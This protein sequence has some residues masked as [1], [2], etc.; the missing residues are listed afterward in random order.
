MRKLAWLIIC[1]VLLTACGTSGDN[2][3]EVDTPEITPAPQIEPTPQIEPAPD[4]SP[5]ELL[6]GYYVNDEGQTILNFQPNEGE[7]EPELFREYFFGKWDSD[8]WRD[9]LIDDAAP[10]HPDSTAFLTGRISR[11]GDVLV[12]DF[13]DDETHHYIYW[14]DTN[15]PNIM[16]WTD[17][18]Y[19]DEGLWKVPVASGDFHIR[20]YE[21]TDTPPRE[22]Q[23][24]FISRL[25][26]YELMRE[27]EIEHDMMFFIEY[28]IEDK[29]Y[30]SREDGRLLA[31]TFLVLQEPEKLIFDTF[32]NSP[33]YEVPPLDVTVTIEKIDGEWVRTLEFDEEYIKKLSSDEIMPWS[34]TLAGILGPLESI[35]Y[36]IDDEGDV[37]LDRAE[38]AISDT[39]TFEQ[40]F[41]GRWLHYISMDPDRALIIDDSEEF[42]WSP[43]EIYVA[44]EN[45]IIAVFYREESGTKAEIWWVDGDTP[46]ELY[47]QYIRGITDT[48]FDVGYNV[49]DVYYATPMPVLY[50]LESAESQV[51]E[52]QVAAESA[53]FTA[54]L[55]ALEPYQQRTEVY[56]RFYPHSV[57]EFIPADNYGRIY[58]FPAFTSDNIWSVFYGFMT[59]DGKVIHD[60]IYQS[61]NFVDK[62]D[63]YYI[64]ERYIVSGANESTLITADGSKA[65]TVIGSFQPLGDGVIRVYEIRGEFNIY[66]EH[67]EDL[68]RTVPDEY[69]GYMDIDGNILEPFV[70]VYDNFD[71]Y[72]FDFSYGARIVYLNKQTGEHFTNFDK[73]YDEVWIEDEWRFR[74]LVKLTPETTV[75]GLLE[76][77]TMVEINPN[78]FAEWD[79]I[80]SDR[81]GTKFEGTPNRGS[82]IGNYFT[83]KINEVSQIYDLNF[84]EITAPDGFPRILSHVGAEVYV[85]G[86]GAENGED[87]RYILY[88]MASGKSFDLER[89]ITFRDG[90]ITSPGVLIYNEYIYD[91][92]TGEKRRIFD[93]LD[94]AAHYLLDCG[95]VLFWLNEDY[96]YEG[97]TYQRRLGYKLYTAEGEELLPDIYDTIRS[98]GNGLYEVR[99]KDNYIGVIRDNGEWIIKIDLLKQ[100]D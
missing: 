31:R 100:R 15:R 46:N 16:Y 45:T 66:Y 24:N 59:A 48:R 93:G 95:R 40:Y 52:L 20:I 69:V 76:V 96:I 97:K 73:T 3:G 22:P 90:L 37:Y 79:G 18:L 83:E 74:F 85:F 98:L 5:L 81:D 32:L 92:N 54:R 67:D 34:F 87:W 28:E 53:G 68:Y 10:H 82:F 62:D 7:F 44:G 2:S 36:H 61:V 80:Y 1:A 84:N 88:D 26:L 72:E 58:P 71:T 33:I 21:K 11:V 91:F 41:F 30:F 9:L 94:V 57:T 17:A 13:A 6:G 35:G 51:A 49:Y 75:E 14:S 77:P 25:R 38:W 23:D 55:A 50:Y 4:L 42:S 86:N 78:F 29:F 60:G 89:Y 43:D 63:G 64:A 56:S 39:E 65:L 47:S 27:Y 8:G 12:N 99:T 19:H 70:R